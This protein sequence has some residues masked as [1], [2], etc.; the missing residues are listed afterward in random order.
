MGKLPLHWQIL[1]ALILGTLG[2]VTLNLFL[3]DK[4]TASRAGAARPWS[5]R[6]SADL[7]EITHEVEGET[8]VYRVD[9][10]Y[11]PGSFP[12]DTTEDAQGRPVHYFHDLEGLRNTSEHPHANPRAYN[13]FQEHG[14][15]WARR[16]GNASGALGSLFLRLL[17]MVSIPLIIASLITGVTSLGQTQRLGRMF[18]R[19]IMYYMLTTVLAILTGLTLVNVIRPGERGNF[20]A[21]AAAA[22]AD[23]APK[24]K[25]L[26]TVL[27]EQLE[28][29]IPTNPFEAVAQSNFLSIISFS[30]AFAIFAIL[31]GG[32][33][34]DT[35]RGIAE[36]SFEVMMKMTMAIIGLAPF[37][38]F[39]LLLAVTATQGAGVFRSLGWY[40]VTVGLGL[41]IHAVVT[42]P[43]ILKFLARRNPREYAE[44]MSP[45]LM[46]AFS[47]ASSNGTL[48][49]TL[50]CVESRAGVSNRVSS[51]VLPL[52]ATVNMDGTALYEVVAVLFI[53]QLTPG[54]DLG[55]PQQIIVVVTALLASVGAAGIPHAGLVM[56]VIILQAVG[57]P[58]EKQALIIAVDRVLDMGRTAVN[59]WSDSCGCAVVSRFE[60]GHPEPGTPLPVPER[61]EPT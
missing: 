6:D 18:G 2:G 39:F 20:A 43:L 17:K 32:P 15:S 57:L 25:G 4:E 22:A 8:H 60:V 29:L 11:V 9:P 52:G 10:S 1:I 27:W 31:A 45:A 37:G 47:S 42:M 13:L 44:A 7:I 26:G 33:M 56:M 50:T 35:V 19:T 41:A 34:L 40:M 28:N 14:Q 48:P 49:L 58:T 46:T 21:Q 36:A 38:V 3:S 12:E 53:A 24:A 55:L 59:V 16:V 23:D 61:D 5:I 54:V 30:L 51:F